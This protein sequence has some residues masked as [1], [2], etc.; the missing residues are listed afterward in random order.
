MKI[1]YLKKFLKFIPTSYYQVR[2]DYK[3][4]YSDK[5]ISGKVALKA[6]LDLTDSYLNT[7]KYHRKLTFVSTE[8]KEFKILSNDN[9]EI[10]TILIYYRELRLWKL[11][12][13]LLKF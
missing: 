9:K 3:D 8:M 2:V 5:L 10:G 6:Y 1:R 7:K 12:K 4:Y 11:L 13:R